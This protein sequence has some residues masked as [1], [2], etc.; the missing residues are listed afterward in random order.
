MGRGHN[1]EATWWWMSNAVVAA[2]T[3]HVSGIIHTESTTSWSVDGSNRQRGVAT[4]LLIV[5]KR[6]SRR[7]TGSLGAQAGTLE[8][9][10]AVAPV[11]PDSDY[12]V[13]A[14]VASREVT[15]THALIRLDVDCV[16]LCSTNPLCVPVRH[17]LQYQCVFSPHDTFSFLTHTCQHSGNNTHTPITH[18]HDALRHHPHPQC[19]PI[20][21]RWSPASGSRIRT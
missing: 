16:W 17:T 1:R 9:V 11:P 2:E 3:S 6:A 21:A 7:L 15:L 20:P 13:S 14:W 18:P 4:L 19:H 12:Q 10:T 8:W 5:Y